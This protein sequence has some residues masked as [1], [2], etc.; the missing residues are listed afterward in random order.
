[1]AYDPATGAWKD[2]ETDVESRINRLTSPDS[3]YMKAAEAP[4]LQAANRRGLLNST[5]AVQSGQAARL[6]AAL[7]IASQDASQANQRAMQGR[8]LQ[9][10][11][12]QQTRG[13]QSNEA[14]TREGYGLQRELQAGDIAGRERMQERQIT[15]DK[16]LQATDNATRMQMQA[17]DIE[18]QQRIANLNVAAGERSDA[19]RAAV[20]FE[21]TYAAMLEAIMSN[22]DIPAEARQS[23]MDHAARI[24]DNNYALIEQMYG[25]EL[26]WAA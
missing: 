15:A 26:D 12:I 16:E 1:M 9:S 18:S 13:I 8:A 14:L 21:S 19:T 5:M 7:P 24:R 17:L 4:A 22:P 10:S 25:I 3:A 20:A 23:Y 11:D 2:E 6:Q